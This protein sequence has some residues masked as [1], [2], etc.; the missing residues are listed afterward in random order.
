MLLCSSIL[1]LAPAAAFASCDS[2]K[3]SIDANLKPKKLAGYSL[4][5]ADADKAADGKVVGHCDGGKKVLVY[6]REGAAKTAPAA[7][8]PEKK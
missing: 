4:T 7:P 2:L 5:V 6:K 8:E 1:L 3:A